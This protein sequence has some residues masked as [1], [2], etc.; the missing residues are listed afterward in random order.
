MHT[1]YGHIYAQTLTRTCPCVTCIWLLYPAPTGAQDGLDT[2]QLVTGVG[3]L[4]AGMETDCVIVHV[5]WVP[6][7]DDW[8]LF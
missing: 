3:S 1:T 6:Q 8:R 4:K 2:L 7:Y 5:G